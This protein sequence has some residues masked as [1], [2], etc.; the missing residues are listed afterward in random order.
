MHLTTRTS[1]K[2]AVIIHFVTWVKL[3]NNKCN[4]HMLFLIL[5]SIA[6]A[7]CGD[8]SHAT[9]HMWEPA[10]SHAECQYFYS[11]KIPVIKWN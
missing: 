11:V 5:S 9:F 2:E 4:R 10:Q 7:D 3:T 1:W 6:V 8:L